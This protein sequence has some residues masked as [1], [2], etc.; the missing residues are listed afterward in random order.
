MLVIPEEGEAGKFQR[1][2]VIPQFFDG[3]EGDIPY[4]LRKD[5]DDFDFGY[6]LTVHKAQG[7]GKAEIYHLA[8]N[9]GMLDQQSALVAFTR[10][11]KGS[12]R[13]YTTDDVMERMTERLGT[14]RHKEM[15]LSVGLSET[16][17]APV[18]NLVQDV[19]ELLAG[20]KPK[21]QVPVEKQKGPVLTL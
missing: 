12:Y 18:R 20:L 14:E 17:A 16:Q 7:Q 21:P 15:A 11:T 19:E 13:M 2:A 1:V 6:A 5:S 9:L 3:G 8:T 4:A 10:L